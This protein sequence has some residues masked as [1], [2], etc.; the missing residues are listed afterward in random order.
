MRRTCARQHP[1]RSTSAI[2]S[3]KISS[4]AV[5]T[6]RSITSFPN[7]RAW[8]ALGACHAPHQVRKPV[9][10][11][12]RVRCL[13]KGGR[14]PVRIGWRNNEHLESSPYTNCPSATM[15]TAHWVITIPRTRDLC[16][17]YNQRT[18]GCSITPMFSSPVVV[19]NSKPWANSTTPSF[20]FLTTGRRK[21][22]MALVNAY[23][24]LNGDRRTHSD[25]DRPDRRYLGGPDTH[26]PWL[27]GAATRRCVG[28]NKHRRRRD[29]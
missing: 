23:W 4:N 6:P 11:I 26:L 14:R 20:W 16:D 28:T 29:L 18:P 5:R 9:D 17:A 8:V 3:P 12:V 10:R 22:A 7:D 1:H 15:I 19:D 2:T 13:P 24:S 21:K 25:Q 27:V